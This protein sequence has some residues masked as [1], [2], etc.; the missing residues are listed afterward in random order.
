MNSQFQKIISLQEDR[1][2]N[3]NLLNN[4]EISSIN[5]IE[6]QKNNIEF[7]LSQKNIKLEK[8]HSNNITLIQTKEKLLV[9]R[10]K[11]DTDTKNEIQKI[12]EDISKTRIKHQNLFFIKNEEELEFNKTQK[13]KIIFYEN[14]LDELYIEKKNTESSYDKEI[15][16]L[17]DKNVELHTQI[18]TY[19]DE[20]RK[21]NQLYREDI[22]QR[23]DTRND[24]IL[25]II[26]YKQIDRSITK[27]R[28]LLRNQL[29]EAE[30]AY[31]NYETESKELY[32]LKLRE[33]ND[34]LIQFKKTNSS[35]TEIDTYLK[36]LTSDLKKFKK[37]METEKRKKKYKLSNLQQDIKN[38]DITQELERKDLLNEK[39]NN[40]D[41]LSNIK[42][43]K[44][45]SAKLESEIKF[46]LFLIENLIHKKKDILD[47]IDS[48]ILENDFC[49]LENKNKTYQN[50]ELITQIE[51]KK[52]TLLK[53]EKEQNY[54]LNYL[55]QQKYEK[56]LSLNLIIQDIE[57][58]ENTIQKL[59]MEIASYQK[60]LIFF[61]KKLIF[62]NRKSQKKIQSNIEN[63]NKLILEELILLKE[64]KNKYKEIIIKQN[65]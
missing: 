31:H 29:I 19:Q 3:I 24:N 44:C 38:L 10:D 2:K 56:K 40:T 60:K 21:L 11:N 58:N 50:T 35:F 57:N 54:Y 34:K 13:L 39:K 46:N 32:E 12:K 15:L 48:K 27:K 26:N 49:L 65:K 42:N 23:F 30:I 6:T 18:K 64:I 1:I 4:H 17:E 9:Q 14:S 45:K 7:S 33:N 61:N 16:I 20:I 51:E 28:K 41:Y 62:L 55:H 8:L 59:A 43:L 37:N 52:E 22:S 47:K 53:L 25:H 36:K 63:N 5:C